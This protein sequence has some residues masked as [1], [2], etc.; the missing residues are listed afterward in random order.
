MFENV[1][2]RKMN[3]KLTRFIALFLVTVMLVVS[4]QPT[5]VGA[6]TGNSVLISREPVK[7][8]ITPNPKPV[9]GK[10][11][12]QNNPV[13]PA[14]NQNNKPRITTRM[15]LRTGLGLL[16]RIPVPYKDAIMAGSATVTIELAQLTGE[17]KVTW[18][19]IFEAIKRGEYKLEDMPE[20]EP[21]VAA[22]QKYQC[23][24]YDIGKSGK[25][26]SATPQ[27]ADEK[28]LFELANP[29]SETTIAGN[30]IK[31]FGDLPNAE[32]LSK[33][34]GNQPKN[35]AEYRTPLKY[36]FVS[37]GRKVYLRWFGT[38]Y[39]VQRYEYKFVS[40]CGKRGNP[41]SL[42]CETY[43]NAQKELIQD[44]K[45]IKEQFFNEYSPR[46][47]TKEQLVAARK[48]AIAARRKADGNFIDSIGKKLPEVARKISDR[49]M[50]DYGDRLG[51]TYDWYAKNKKNALLGWDVGT[52]AASLRD[53]LVLSPGRDQ[54]FSGLEYDLCEGANK[55][56]ELP[57][58]E[59]MKQA[60]KSKVPK[61]WGEGEISQDGKGWRWNPD[62]ANSVRIEKAKPNSQY[63]SQQVDYV[64]ITSGGKVI[65]KNGKPVNS[66]AEFPKPS[67]APEAHIPLSNWLNWDFWNKP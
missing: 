56:A 42:E 67:F 44:L 57:P 7:I 45:K 51:V 66:T 31:R 38:I 62:K 1:K 14:A 5:L 55:P 10:P 58:A 3:R 13:P 41:D 59:Q 65:G 52:Q 22:P 33:A 16:L 20:T 24:D 4:F 30:F 27:N 35:W 48:N 26:P 49:N 64:K 28:R 11:A 47:T 54:F 32:R 2:K 60:G 25:L 46:S 43:R 34:Y 15:V 12:N 39:D 37:E 19:D 29:N 18:S 53:Y 36:S 8:L 50:A 17:T 9:D 21:V 6:N 23:E 40:E 61:D 63:P